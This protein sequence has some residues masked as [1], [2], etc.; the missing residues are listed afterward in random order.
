[1]QNLNAL[2]QMAAKEGVATAQYWFINYDISD[3]L[4]VDTI[5]KIDK[6]K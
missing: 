6:V 5:M 3:R 2:H 1:M 4:V